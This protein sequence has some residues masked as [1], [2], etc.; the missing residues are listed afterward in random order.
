MREAVYVMI[1]NS[2][3]NYNKT[4]ADLQSKEKRILAKLKTVPAKEHDYIGYKRNQEILQGIYLLLLQKREETLLSLGQ[5]KDRARVIEP[6]FVK[7]KTVNPRKLYAA[8]AILILTL[9][10]P[11]AIILSKELFVSLKEEYKKG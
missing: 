4:L 5:D 1:N 6:A 10:L 11:I 3:K 2:R 7:K 9:V 8:I